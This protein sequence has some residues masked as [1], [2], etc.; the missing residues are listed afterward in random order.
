M[1]DPGLHDAVV[2]VTGDNNPEDIADAVLWL[3]SEQAGWIT[4]E[5]LFVH[6]GHRLAL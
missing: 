5:H 3:A 6:G 1:I 4:G 2:I